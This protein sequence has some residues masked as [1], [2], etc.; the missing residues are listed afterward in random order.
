MWKAKSIFNEKND[1]PVI[2]T[3]FVVSSG[4]C[5]KFMQRHGFSLRQKTTTAQKDPSYLND[6]IAAYV[7]HVRRIQ[8]QFNFHDANIIVMD[9]T[10]VWNDMVSNTTVEK[11]VSKEIPMKSTG[12]NK[13]RVDCNTRMIVDARLSPPFSN[14]K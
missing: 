3:S 10:S 4:W 13:V 5:E 6:R 14:V 7:M 11:T 1:H 12:H 8:K 9:E 2:K